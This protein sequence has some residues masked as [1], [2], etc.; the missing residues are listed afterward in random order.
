MSNEIKKETWFD[1]FDPEV[2]FYI[3][4]EKFPNQ[5][6]KYAY[7]RFTKGNN[8]KGHEIILMD[9]FN[10]HSLNWYFN[11]FGYLGWNHLFADEKAV[12][13]DD[14]D[15]TGAWF[16]VM[17]TLNKDRKIDG[18]SYVEAFTEYHLQ[19]IQSKF[20]N[21]QHK[22]QYIMELANREKDRALKALESTTS[23]SLENIDVEMGE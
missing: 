19:N 2:A 6:G 9:T 7:P 15:R 8:K 20:D 3:M 18:K 10:N 4:K 17:S 11:Q 23:M 12:I 5:I 14:L 22:S 13:G 1:T 21:D 16:E